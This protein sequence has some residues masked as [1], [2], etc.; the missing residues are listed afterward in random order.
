MNTNCFF[1]VLFLDYPRILSSCDDCDGTKSCFSV[2]SKTYTLHSCCSAN[3]SVSLPNALKKNNRN[4]EK[5]KLKKRVKMD[6]KKEEQKEFVEEETEEQNKKIDLVLSNSGKENKN[7]DLLSAVDCFAKLHAR[8]ENL[9]DLLRNLPGIFF[10]LI[11][12]LIK[13][14]WFNSKRKRRGI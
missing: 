4:R 11:L 2:G 7:I 8:I 1:F 5:H 3:D 6:L 14:N 13:V 9:E 10:N 12:F